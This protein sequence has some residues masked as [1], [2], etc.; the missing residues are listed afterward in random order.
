[1]STNPH[2][3]QFPEQSNG[4][5]VIVVTGPTAVGKTAVAIAIAKK[6][7]TEIISADSRQCYKEMAIGVARPSLQEL[8]TVPHHFIAS[9]AVSETVNAAVFEQYALQK[10]QEIFKEKNVLV[11]AGGTGLYIKAFCEGM[12][13]MPDIPGTVRHQ[14]RANYEKYGLPW[15]QQEIQKKDPVFYQHG[16]IQNPHRVMRA[17]E[18]VEATG[19]SIFDF[20]TG[21]KSQRNFQ[22]L[23]IGLTL[24]K[25]ELHRNINERTDKMIAEGLEEEVKSL[26]QYRH[27][28]A[29]QTVGYAEM[30]DYLNGNSSLEQAIERIKMNTR[31]YAKRQMTWFKKDQQIQ[32]FSPADFTRIEAYLEKSI[33]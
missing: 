18:V 15:L 27:V 20:R 33:R 4:K 29:L 19:N 16:E 13:E 6:Y 30:I 17:L 12:D 26:W 3:D 2:T 11:L 25:D 23:K 1:M 10:A 5:T 24:P 28:N 31:R 7:H 22:V 8:Q 14:I 21:T 9:H 32:W